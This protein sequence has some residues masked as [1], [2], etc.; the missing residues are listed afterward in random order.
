[1]IDSADISVVVQG[2]VYEEV[3]PA[4]LASVRRFLPRAEIIFSTCDKNAAQKISGYDSLVL[5]DD[6]GNFVYGNQP[7]EKANNV[8]R[9]IVNTKAGLQ[10]VKTSYAMKLRSDF[11]LTGN[12]FLRFFELFPLADKKYQVFTHKLLSCCWFARNPRSNMP[13]PFHPSDLVFFGRTEDLLRLYDIPLMSREEAYWN[14]NDKHQYRY[15]PEQYI[16]LNCLRKNGFA[17]D[18]GFY[19]DCNENNIRQ[20]EQYFASNFVFLTFEQFNLK[21]T[22]PNFDMRV[23]LKAFR[24]CYTHAEWQRLYQ[25]YAAPDFAVSETDEVREK[26]ET[27]YKK[28]KK[29]RF[30]SNLCALPFR[31][32]ARRRKI[33]NKV[34]EFF[35]R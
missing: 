13:Y 2:G 15:V 3:T 31:G 20:T 14:K 22:K 29:F 9:Q 11:L 7:E 19:N 10:V 32:K 33:R 8:N 27:L 26:I 23:Q 17:A 30:L 5:S 21:P 18:C 24:N 12:D 16:W 6:P 25:Q 28:Y 34:L 35:L 1:M 4:V